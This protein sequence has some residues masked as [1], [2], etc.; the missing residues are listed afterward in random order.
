MCIKK[1]RERLKLKEWKLQK[2][3]DFLFSFFFLKKKYFIKKKKKKQFFVFCFMIIN[4]DTF[5]KI[6][7]LLLNRG[8]HY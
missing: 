3:N 2:I 8:L 6:L 4:I 1:F 5:F 7:F